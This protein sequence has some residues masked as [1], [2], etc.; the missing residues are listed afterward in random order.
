MPELE[1]DHPVPLLR[2]APTGAEYPDLLRYVAVSRRGA[3]AE[4]GRRP[5]KAK[6]QIELSARGLWRPGA[7]GTCVRPGRI[8]PPVRR[9]IPGPGTL[10]LCRAFR[11]PTGSLGARVPSGLPLWQHDPRSTALPITPS[12]H[13]REI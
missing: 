2:H 5:E 1:I 9:R 6:M 10:A 12:P 4:Q 13:H 11:H 8:A 3:L 7:A